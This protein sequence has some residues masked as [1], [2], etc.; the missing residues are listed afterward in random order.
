MTKTELASKHLSDLPQLAADA[1]VERY[2]MLTR[3]EL[4]ERLSDGNG[5]S[6]S[7]ASS[8]APSRGRSSAASG[9]DEERPRRRRRRSGGGSGREREERVDEDDEEPT[10]ARGG[11]S[12][13]PA[14]EA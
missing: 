14:P 6:G 4:I 7:A 5:D 1:G 11:R 9:G 12:R 8:E 10:P 2:R 13:K 3:A